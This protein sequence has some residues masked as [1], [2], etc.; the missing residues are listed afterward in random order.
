[1]TNH[2][3]SDPFMLFSYVNTQ[4]RDRY[5]SLQEFC[6]AEDVDPKEL[7]AKLKAA[8]FEYN[9]EQNKFW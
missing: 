7:E 8:G 3:P 5:P 9:K 1:M 4:L 2:L 6:K